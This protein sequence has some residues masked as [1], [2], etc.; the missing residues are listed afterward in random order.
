MLSSGTLPLRS[1]LGVYPSYCSL[2][3]LSKETVY[4]YIISSWASSIN[5]RARVIFFLAG[6]EKK[7]AARPKVTAVE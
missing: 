6:S 4:C 3:E 7:E 2:D 5:I 1:W